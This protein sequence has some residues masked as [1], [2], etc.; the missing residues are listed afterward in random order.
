M[1]MTTFLHYSKITAILIPLSTHY[2][3]NYQIFFTKDQDYNT[4]SLKILKKIHE[5]SQINP[6]ERTPCPSP[7]PT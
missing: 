3:H 2:S 5:K 1:T 6:K 4:I 7:K